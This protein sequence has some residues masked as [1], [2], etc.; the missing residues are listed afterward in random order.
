MRIQGKM[1]A[2]VLCLIAGGQA[3]GGDGGPGEPPPQHLLQRMHPVGGWHPYGGGLL[4]WWNPHCFPRCG[5]PDDYCRKALPRVC[6]PPYPPYYISG[7]PEICYR[8]SIGPRDC[9]KPH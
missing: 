2:L 1:W 9:N 3:L 6:W 7:P 4:H 8:R 5:G